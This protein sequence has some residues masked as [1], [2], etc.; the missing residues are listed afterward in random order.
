MI[1]FLQLPL[2]W[3]YLAQGAKRCHDLGNSGWWQLIPF[4]GVF[5]LFQ[6]SEPGVNKYGY[7]PKA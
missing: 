5:L 4:Y 6:N 1:P 2:L 7:N 3:F